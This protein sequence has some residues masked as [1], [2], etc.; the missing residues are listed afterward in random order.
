MPKNG[1]EWN[2]RTTLN[3]QCKSLLSMYNMYMQVSD[4]RSCEKEVFKGIVAFKSLHLEA[5]IVYL[6]VEP[7]SIITFL[8]ELH[9]ISYNGVIIKNVCCHCNISL[10]SGQVKASGKN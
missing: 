5:Q 6:H 10:S 4:N 8:I 7:D 9:R 2:Y 3:L 1:L